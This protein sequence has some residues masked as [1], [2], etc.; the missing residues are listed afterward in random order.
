MARRTGICAFIL[1]LGLSGAALAETD[2]DKRAEDEARLNLAIE[3]CDKGAAIPRD[4]DAKAPVVHFAQ[5]YM[6]DPDR[7]KNVSRLKELATDC[8]AAGYG[9]PD[10]KRLRLQALRPQVMLLKLSFDR[11]KEKQDGKAGSLAKEI[12]GYAEDG[13]AEANFL[14]FQLYDAGSTGT[15]E[16]RAGIGR[17]EAVKA[18]HTAGNDG[19]LEALMRLFGEYQRGPHMRRD[20][21][22]AGL[23]G[24]MIANLPSQGPGGP[25]QYETRS[26]DI[27]RAD[28]AALYLIRDGFTQEQQ[29]S[30]FGVVKAAFEAKDENA[31][32]PYVT[33]LRMGRGTAADPAAARK[34]AEDAVAAGNGRALASLAE[35]LANG[36]GG[37]ADGKRALSLLRAKKPEQ[38][39]SDAKVVLAGFYL[40]NKLTGRRP[41]DAIRLLTAGANLDADRRAAALLIDYQQKLVSPYSLH[42]RLY[43]AAVVGEPGAAMALVRLQLSGNSD[44]RDADETHRLLVNLAKDGDAEAKVLLAGLQ[45]VRL[46]SGFN[47][48]RRYN[49]LSD[50]ALR[51]VI[52]DGIAAG[53]GSA[54]R[55]KAQLTRVGALYPQDDAA[56][57]KLLLQAAEHGDIQ[58]MLLAGKA[59]DDGLGI[60][61]NPR[62]R[63]RWW[64]EAAK[65][66]SVDARQRLA[67]AFTFDF[68]NKLMTLREGITG[69]VALYNDAAGE[70]E[71]GIADAGFMSARLTGL[72]SG[73]TASSAGTGPLA[74]ATLDAFRLAPA[75]LEEA[76]LLPFMRAAP[77]EI[78]VEMEKVL[79]KDGFYK[80]TPSGNFGPD[81]RAALATWVDAKGPLVDEPEAKPVAAATAMP[82]LPQDLVLRVQDRAFKAAL[83]AK[84]DKERA[85]ALKRINALAAYGDLASRWALMRN[86]HTA[87]VVRSVVSAEEI[88]R[89]GLDIVAKRP[90]GMEKVDF[91]FIFDITAIYEGGK[92]GAFGAATLAAIRDD[93]A[94]QDALTLGSVM[95]Q[96]NFAP[97][98]CD[99]ILDAAKKAKVPGIG[100]EGCEDDTRAGLI[101][102][103]KDKGPAGVDKKARES[104]TAEVA[105]LDKD[106]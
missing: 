58:A 55:L 74:Q 51:K 19:H 106:G 49:D 20:F 47:P 53:Q 25:S 103:A 2:A 66:G 71:S 13:S 1:A 105:K 48:P 83:A 26:Q 5:F 92:I 35:M 78:R 79:A 52:E 89:Y 77:Q 82:G 8:V 7:E 10:E 94:L 24:R 75:G 21:K 95:D 62:E 97:G 30:G 33:A 91:E 104:A 64:R 80:G 87:K 63:L 76:R 84:T 59:L 54:F 17:E 99:A 31:V 81:V 90:A 14:L 93:A 39:S 29:A 43:P 96:I 68:F 23:I 32:L 98:A 86:Y 18:L 56:A 72:Y 9:A 22:S 45:F 67:N 73:G 34:V 57:T 85:P 11:D 27:A 38:L 50:D 65:L 6:L 70:Y 12:R 36:E 4:R 101:A 61:K 88:T 37:P 28:L 3:A 100:S 46:D 41:R 60:E 44:F 40:D 16:S 69:R 42:D 102:W 15:F